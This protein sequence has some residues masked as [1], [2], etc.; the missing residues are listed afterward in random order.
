MQSKII[1]FIIGAIF[2]AGI[3]YLIN[4]ANVNSPK[5]FQLKNDYRIGIVGNLKKGTIL[6]LDKGMSEGF[7]RYILYLNLKYD[8]VGDYTIEKKDEIIPYWLLPDTTKR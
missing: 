6:R 5:Y 7:T 3:I 4:S 8:D 2:G 1:I